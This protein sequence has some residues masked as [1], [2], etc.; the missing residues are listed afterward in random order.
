MQIK[1]ELHNRVLQKNWFMTVECRPIIG[2]ILLINPA[3]ISL[4]KIA[5]H[6]NK[7]KIRYFAL[8]S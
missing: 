7:S 3:L 6:E 8:V 2:T 5:D 4:G 1:I